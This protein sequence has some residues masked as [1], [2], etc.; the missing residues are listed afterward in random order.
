M[1]AMRQRRYP[2]VLAAFEGP[3]FP[4]SLAGP[5]PLPGLCAPLLRASAPPVA[6]LT[7]G[8]PGRHSRA[9]TWQESEQ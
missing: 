2:P 4:D 1:S 3:A 8:A 7:R 6:R 5:L 9:K